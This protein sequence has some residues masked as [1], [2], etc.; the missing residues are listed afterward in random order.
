[1]SMQRNIRHNLT[2][3]CWSFNWNLHAYK[4][5]DSARSQAIPIESFIAIEL[6][7]SEKTKWRHVFFEKTS[8]FYDQNKVI[9]LKLPTIFYWNL[10]SKQSPLF[11]PFITHINTPFAVSCNLSWNCHFFFIN[12]KICCYIMS[13]CWRDFSAETKAKHEVKHIRELLR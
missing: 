13:Y 11:Y 2:F 9:K 8:S 6:V 3:I 4:F 10:I 5:T 7:V 1:M 12:I